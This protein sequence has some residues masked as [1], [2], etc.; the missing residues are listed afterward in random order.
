MSAKAG[1]TAGAAADSRMDDSATAAEND[2][3]GCDLAAAEHTTVGVLDDF[4]VDRL[5]F[6]VGFERFVGTVRDIFLSSSSSSSS[7]IVE[8]RRRRT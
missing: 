4:Q 6:K 8:R 2:C 1:G 3:S 5:G 7:G